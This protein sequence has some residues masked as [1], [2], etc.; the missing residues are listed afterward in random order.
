MKARISAVCFL[1]ALCV[2][3]A[4]A[5]E[6]YY[7]GAASGGRPGDYLLC[8]S[9][10]AAQAASGGS[11]SAF[12]AG[13]SGIY[14]NPASLCYL[15]KDE[16]TVFYRPLY[17]GGNYY[18][19]G[20]GHKFGPVFSLPKDSYMGV[21]AVGTESA[22]AEKT[23]LLRESQG[24]FYNKEQSLI[25]SFAYPLRDNIAAG[26]NMK[27]LTQ[28]MDGYRAG[29]FGADVGII[30]F[31]K[32]ANLSFCAQNIVQPSL[33]LKDHTDEYPLNLIFGASSVFDNGKIVPSADIIISGSGK[34]RSFLWKTGCSYLI[35][36]VF[37]VSG[38]LNYKEL[39]AGFGVK[40]DPCSVNYA[41]TFHE[42]GIKHM[43][44]VKMYFNTA[45]GE[46]AKLY[47]SQRKELENRSEELRKARQI[48]DRL[49]KAAIES[50]LSGKYELARSEFRKVSMI[51]SD[52]EEDINQLFKMEMEIEEK[53]Q[54]QKIFVLFTAAQKNLRKSEFDACLKKIDEILNMA[55]ANKSAVLLQCKCLAYRALNNGE[56]LEAEGFLEDA[57]KVSPG[58]A[59]ISKLLRRLRKF[60]KDK[61]HLKKE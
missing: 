10:D 13:L 2:F 30:S 5:A 15:E 20:G 32:R 27:L 51:A 3:F 55:P 11:G 7:S 47:Y 28:S 9:A 22:A 24:S 23:T 48:Y 4:N 29:S 19:I 18:F 56:Y 45:A 33:R 31:L 26:V 36:P 39:S 6:A 41:F 14:L 57:L 21:S 35:S 1:T 40:M 61:K 25:F 8:L 43:L 49:T 46:E 34:T 54:K 44:S 37:S 58:N 52:D 16:L 17:D 42:L 53:V 38:G 12:K 50:F 60:I 59:G